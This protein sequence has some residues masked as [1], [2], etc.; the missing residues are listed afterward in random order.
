MKLYHLTNELGFNA[1]ISAPNRH[2]AA[3]IFLEKHD[4]EFAGRRAWVRG[5]HFENVAANAYENREYLLGSRYLVKSFA[6]NPQQSPAR[7]GALL[8]AP[9]DALLGTS[10]IGR[11]AAWR[12]ARIST[13]R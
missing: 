3:E 10:L 5:K 8:L 13:A 7:L 4:A 6:A 12:R 9:V 11:A 2:K 1:H